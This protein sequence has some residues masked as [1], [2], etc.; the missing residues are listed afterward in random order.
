MSKTNQYTW[1]RPP[2][3]SGNGGCNGGRT[4]TSNDQ[5][6][7]LTLA[8]R[9]Q[10]HPLRHQGSALQTPAPDGT[11]IDASQRWRR[12]GSSLVRRDGNQHTDA[13]QHRRCYPKKTKTRNA[14]EGKNA[15]NGRKNLSGYTVKTRCMRN[16]T[17]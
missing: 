13:M 14:K 9:V 16:S 11:P 15:E 10:G 6:I 17:Y 3:A 1:H 4:A 2:Q 12:Q 5:T 7:P 8:R